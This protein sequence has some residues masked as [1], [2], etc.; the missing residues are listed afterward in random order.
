MHASYVRISFF[1]TKSH[2]GCLQS[3]AKDT[4][5]SA[6]PTINSR[7]ISNSALKKCPF[8]RSTSFLECSNKLILK[9]RQ[10][11]YLVE[12]LGSQRNKS[13]D[14]SLLWWVEILKCDSE[15]EPFRRDCFHLDFLKAGGVRVNDECFSTSWPCINISMQTKKECSVDHSC[16]QAKEAVSTTKDEICKIPSQNTK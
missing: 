16:S 5:C 4:L 9:A 14:F 7:N 8:Y 11:F 6:I 2:S 10:S 13:W 15:L 12:T 3:I 1:L